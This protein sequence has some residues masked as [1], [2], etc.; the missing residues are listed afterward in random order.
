MPVE[1]D[2]SLGILA[3]RQSVATVMIDNWA[4]LPED[5]RQA[6][7]DT[8]ARPSPVDSLVEG[9]EAAY[10]AICAMATPP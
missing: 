8:L 7:S 6:L 4:D 3:V 9:M 2:T 5:Q 10:G 1:I